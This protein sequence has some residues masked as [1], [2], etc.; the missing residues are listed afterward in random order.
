M[1]ALCYLCENVHLL[2]S[3]IKMYVFTRIQ[4]KQ[5]CKL[6]TR[7]KKK[8]QFYRALSAFYTRNNLICLLKASKKKE[9]L[10]KQRLNYMYKQKIKRLFKK[11]ECFKRRIITFQLTYGIFDE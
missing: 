7:R 4:W 8:L 1:H 6:W 5:W 3:Y 10:Y 11:L 2:R 9:K